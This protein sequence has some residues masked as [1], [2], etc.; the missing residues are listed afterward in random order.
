MNAQTPQ[1]KK[2]K[3]KLF[4]SN[5]VALEE[6]RQ[7]NIIDLKGIFTKNSSSPHK[8]DVQNPGKGW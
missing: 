5:K 3:N 1:I 2:A 7:K 8:K 6:P 4:K